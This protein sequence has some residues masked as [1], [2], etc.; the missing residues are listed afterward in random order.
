MSELEN[1]PVPAR[2]LTEDEVAEGITEVMNFASNLPDGMEG[3]KHLAATFAVYM[4]ETGDMNPPKEV[5]DLALLRVIAG[6]ETRI[7]DLESRLK[8][9]G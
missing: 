3:S 8:T 4:D 1:A 7:K 6:L 9:L 5:L 2:V